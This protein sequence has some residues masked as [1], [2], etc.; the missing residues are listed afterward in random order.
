MSVGWG[1]GGFGQILW[2]LGDPFRVAGVQPIRENLLRL[3]FNFQ[4][5]DTALEE[6]GDATIVS[7]YVVTPL[8][9]T[10]GYDAVD[11]RPVSVASVE[12][13]I[14]EGADNRFYDLW[15]DRAMSPY[16]S[17]YQVKVSNVLDLSG[18]QLQVG[19]DFATTFALFRGL[20][21][22]LAEVVQPSRDLANKDGLYGADD[23]GDYRTDA[24][25][26]SFKKRV[27]RRLITRRGS[28]AHLPGYGVGTLDE[29]KQLARNSTRRKL[30]AQAEEQIGLEPE[31]EKVRAHLVRDAS[32]PGLW[33]FIILVRARNSLALRIDSPVE[34]LQL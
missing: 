31:T 10:I 28:F 21:P 3:E 13:A 27:L 25:L 19:Y 26:A 30:E 14:F 4:P 32:V 15:L 23:T 24:G 22:N 2:G 7:S 1:Q 11:A 16:A 6:D 18:N 17:E 12:R 34:G 29:I 5:K 9:G 20:E 33:R 8:A